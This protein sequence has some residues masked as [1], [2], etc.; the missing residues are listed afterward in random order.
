MPSN[1]IDDATSKNREETVSAPRFRTSFLFSASLAKEVALKTAVWAVLIM[2]ALTGV[3]YVYL[4]KNS[5]ARTLE[6]LKIYVAARVES[7]RFLF[8][9]ARDNMRAFADEFLETYVSDTVFSEEEFDKF[10]FRDEH[11]ATRLRPE[12][13]SGV[14][15]AKGLLF[16]GASGF[17][18]NNQK[19]L[20]PEFKRRLVL[21]YFL[22][23]RLGP[24]WVNRFANLHVSMPENG[25]VIYWPEM[26]WG[27]SARPDLVMTA[28]AVI[29]AT[30]QEFNPE[31]KPV[32]TGLYYDLTANHWMITYQHPL[33]HEGRHLL[34]ASLDV[35]LDDLMNR[36]VARP[37]EGLYNF[38]VSLDGKLVAHPDRL[39]QAKEQKGV[40]DIE[41]LEDPA[42]SR[43]Y[44]ILSAS[45]DRMGQEPVV[46]YDD[47]GENY[48]V[49]TKI[50]GPEWL[51]VSV[52]PKSLLLDRAHESAR[53]ILGLGALLFLS[54]MTVVVL[55]LRRSVAEPVGVLRRASEGISAG[56]Y[57]LLA[58]KEFEKTAAA[59]NEVGMLGRAFRDMA[60]SIQDANRVL[61]E[62]IAVRTSELA[63]ANKQ[64]E[65]LSLLDPLTKAFNRRA[66]DRDME[67]AFDQAQRGKGSFALMLCDVDFFKPYN[68]T[69]GH[70][71]GDRALQ[72]I[73]EAMTASVRPDDRVYRYGGEEI[74]LLFNAP[75]PG[76][77]KEIADRVLDAVRSLNMEHS[78]CPWKKLTV[79][80][81]LEEFSSRHDAPV[82]MIL[83]VDRKLYL[84]KNQGRDRLVT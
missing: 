60:L 43:M 56:D 21:S 63:S 69:Y 13:F 32:W 64:L 79:S 76:K 31:R 14:E 49:A 10:F 66:F 72:R 27:L 62:K 30:L 40:L 46:L 7:E 2:L 5:E 25:L 12:F 42:L 28:G 4:F 74:M 3:A 82:T 9:L 11:G 37:R 16:K 39:H 58:E 51:F 57:S 8:D 29:K 35:Y 50:P 45:A 55:V 77:A 68:D 19:E 20:T 71:A 59:P 53:L 84:A 73:I 34:S 24:A 47:N 44:A 67:R 26:A 61:E 41:K 83:E 15:H 75:H 18:G 80:A 48:L 6:N 23:A 70:E 36:M 54:F 1:D 52:Y 33:D 17:V 81:G 78:A 22:V 65:E 38:I